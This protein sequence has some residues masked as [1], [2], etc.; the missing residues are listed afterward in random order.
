MVYFWIFF[1]VVIMSA[2][3]CYL[4]CNIVKNFHEGVTPMKIVLD[5]DLCSAKAFQ[6]VVTSVHKCG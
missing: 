2:L 6:M 4:R 1:E 5:A 3:F